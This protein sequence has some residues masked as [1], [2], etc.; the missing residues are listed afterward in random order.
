MQEMNQ[1][2]VIEIDLLEVMSVMLHRL[3]LILLCGVL[4][5]GLAFALSAFVVVPQ[6]ESTT[7]IYI[8]NKNENSSLTYSDTQLATQLTKDYE[9]LVKCRYV[10][11][12]VIGTCG[13]EDDYEELE[14]R[15]E[16]EN[17]ADTRII[18]ITVKDPDPVTARAV[19]DCIRDVASEHI[20]NVT[21]VEAVNVV[22]EANLPEEPSE[23]S[24]PLWTAVGALLGIL[25]CAI[26][27]FLR[28]M[29]DD[30][31]KSAEDVEKYLGLSTLALV[32]VM[33]EERAGKKR[34]ERKK[35]KERSAKAEAG[36]M[37]SGEAEEEDELLIADLN[38]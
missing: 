12:T 23:P 31:V 30:T 5:G 14:G 21:D 38:A 16:V 33:E 11:E 18:G 1:N 17:A 24:I 25:L 15:V 20:R 27:V 34:R 29:T 13:L 26:A 19:A 3:W 37:T 35:K 36:E 2:D 9:E 22:D 32:P 8:L 6:Y 10:L 28:Y 7:K 4:A